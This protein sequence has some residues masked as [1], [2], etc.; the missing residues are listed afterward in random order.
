MAT[1]AFPHA[2]RENRLVHDTPRLL[3]ELQR[4]RLD[5]GRERMQTETERG[6]HARELAA[7]HAAHAA[8]RHQLGLAFEQINASV[9]RIVVLESQ[10]ALLAVV[11]GFTGI[12]A[13]LRRR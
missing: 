2:D 13:L 11:A 6:I 5:L 3:A 10:R 9:R 4:L 12:I 7:A 8:T 1:H